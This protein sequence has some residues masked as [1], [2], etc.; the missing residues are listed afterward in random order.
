MAFIVPGGPKPQLRTQI[1]TL[2]LACRGGFLHS[3]T[4][5]LC[6]PSLRNGVIR[7]CTLQGK[8]R[9]ENALRGVLALT[10]AE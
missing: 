3:V 2:P 9:D 6:P 1:P 10:S 7:A 8:S 5:L 4:S